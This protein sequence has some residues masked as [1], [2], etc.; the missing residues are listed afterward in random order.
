[1]V[2]RPRHLH[3]QTRHVLLLVWSVTLLRARSETQH[4]HPARLA[5]PTYMSCTTAAALGPRADATVRS[6]SPPKI[7]VLSAR[8]TEKASGE[9]VRVT[10][11][12]QPPTN[13]QGTWARGAGP[14]GGLLRAFRYAMRSTRTSENG[15]A[16]D[17]IS[18]ARGPARQNHYATREFTSL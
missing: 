8:S 10:D 9:Q 18:S 11:E 13:C 4:P 17:D 14:R 1:M 6:T 5:A 16:K 15:C 7:D 3:V 12:L 2:G